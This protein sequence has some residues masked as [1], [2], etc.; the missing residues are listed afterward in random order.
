[1]IYQQIDGVAM[2]SPLGPLFANIFMSELEKTLIPKVE[3]K[4]NTWTRYVDDTFAFIRRDE[5]KKVEDILNSFE[6]KIQFTHEEE[7]DNIISFLDVQIKRLNDK[8]ETNIYRKKTNTDL[9]INWY[10]H[11]PEIWKLGT[12]RNLVKRAITICSTPDALEKELKYL[13][14]V[15]C[16]TNQYPYKV[17]DG[18][19]DNETKKQKEISEEER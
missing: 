17:V 13:K 12:L 18:I 14:K 19:I 4:L 7:K 11:A 16:E 1:M 9:Y 3:D 6:S 8:L 2:G 10:S 15:F 5:I